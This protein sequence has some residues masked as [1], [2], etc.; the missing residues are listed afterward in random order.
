MSSRVDLV[1]HV[2]SA[3]QFSLDEPDSLEAPT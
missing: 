2:R 1:L 3:D